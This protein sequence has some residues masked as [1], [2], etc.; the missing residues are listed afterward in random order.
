MA[1]NVNKRLEKAMDELKEKHAKGTNEIDDPDRAPTGEAY[2]QH[3][4]QQQ[5]AQK[6]MEQLKLDQENQREQLRQ[7]LHHQELYG[8]NHEHENDNNDIDSDDDDDEFD[9]LLED[10]NDP[11][12]EALRQKRMA[13]IKKAHTQH[14]ENIAKGHGQFRTITQDEFLPECTGSSEWVAIHFFHKDF[15]RCQILDKHLEK[16]AKRH[17]SC[18]FLR[19]DVEKAPFFVAKLAIRTLP[20]LIVFHDGKAVKRLMGFEG[21]SSTEDPDNFPTSRLQTWLADTGA[22]EFDITKDE[23]AREELLQERRRGHGPIWSSA[24]GTLVDDF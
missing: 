7:K 11:V 10:D 8:D 5:Q 9:D 2:K 19:I 12:L 13:E 4:H 14:A 6:A 1:E 24:Q 18:K 23:E 20:T 15:E 16:I 21:L 17:L 22:I 3:Y